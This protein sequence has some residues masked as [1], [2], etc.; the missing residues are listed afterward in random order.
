L[1]HREHYTLLDEPF[2][3]HGNR[4]GLS[5]SWV[6]VIW[7]TPIL[8]QVDHWLNHVEP[9]AEQR[10]YTLRDCKGPPVHPL[11]VSDDHLAAV[12]EALSDNAR[13]GAFAGAL[14]Q[15][16]LR[17]YALQPERVRLDSTTA[18]GYWSVTEDRLFPF[19]HSKDHRP[20][21]PQVKVM[22]SAL[23]SLGLPVATDIMPGQRADAPLSIPAIARVR[24]GLGHR[25]LLYVGDC[26]MGALETRAVVQVGE[27]DDLCPL[28]ELQVPP[29]GLATYLAP[30]WPGAQRLTSLHRVPANGRQELIAE[31]FERLEPL[32]TAVAD[33]PSHWTERRLVIR[34]HQ[35]AQAGERA[36]RARLA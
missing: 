31:G 17:V 18:S 15:H 36:L 25:G 4:V 1:I 24:E 10:L 33:E 28:S 5:L 27:D 21:L 12:L 2:P 8:S 23:D 26:K 29:A 34:S 7:L 19:G 14:T 16:L 9:W 11:D 22:L 3:T 30:V 20:D 6:T 32:T 35:L 13:W